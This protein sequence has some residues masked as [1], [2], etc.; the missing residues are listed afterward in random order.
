MKWILLALLCVAAD[1]CS[2]QDEYLDRS[3]EVVGVADHNRQV[4]YC[5][6]ELREGAVDRFI[7][8]LD[9]EL[10]NNSSNFIRYNNLFDDRVSFYYNGYRHLRLSSAEKSYRGRMLTT[11]DWEEVLVRLRDGRLESAG[12]RGCMLANGKIWFQATE[13]GELKLSSANLEIDW[14]EN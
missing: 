9:A 12:W 11:E 13:Q 8:H 5:G 10:T 2:R 4:P 3:G 7:E 1:G 6:I 14:P